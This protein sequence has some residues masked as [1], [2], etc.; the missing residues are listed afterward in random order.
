M[1]KHA[2]TRTRQ[3]RRQLRLRDGDV[4]SSL[5]MEKSSDT[6]CS[7]PRSSRSGSCDSVGD[8]LVG[9]AA[10][11]LEVVGSQLL[12]MPSPT[13]HVPLYWKVGNGMQYKQLLEAS[14]SDS[15]VVSLALVETE[16]REL[17]GTPV[18]RCRK[19]TVDTSIPSSAPRGLEN[20]DLHSLVDLHKQLEDERKALPGE[21]VVH[22]RVSGL[23]ATML[24][25]TG[26]SVSVISTRLWD[27]IHRSHPGWTLLPTQCRVKTVSGDLAKVRGSLVVEIQLGSKYYAHQ[28]VVID[29][30]EDLILGLD[31]IQKYDLNW[32]KSLG[33][34]LLWGEEVRAVRRYSTGDGRAR[35][36]GL[37]ETTVIP[38][39]TQV[40]VNTK[41][42]NGVKGQL[43]EWG[44]VSATGA[45]AG[46]HGV[47]A[48]RAL[49]DPTR[50][51]IPVPVINPGGMEVVLQ[52]N[53]DIALLLPVDTVG[54][55]SL[56]SNPKTMSD[57]EPD[58]GRKGGRKAL[59]TITPSGETAA[60]CR[61]GTETIQ[62]SNSKHQLAVPPRG[63]V[64]GGTMEKETPADSY[65]KSSAA[66]LGEKETI[67][68]LENE[69]K[70]DS[71]SKCRANLIPT[72]ADTRVDNATK[73]F[74]KGAASGLS[75]DGM[76]HYGRKHWS[77]VSDTE[78]D[79]DSHTLASPTEEEA[80]IPPHL[81]HLYQES[82]TELNTEEAHSLA[83]F[84]VRNADVFAESASD[85]GRT[86]LV[87]HVIDT[88]E[89]LPIKQPPRRVPVHRK[90]LVQ[91]EVG[92]MLSRGVI[93]PSDGPW[94]SPIV[95][96][97]K[98]D[99]TTRFCVDYRRL[100]E[101]T[102][103]DAYPLPR[104]EDNLDALQGAKYFSTLDLISGYWQVEVTPEDR[105][106]TAFTVGGGGLY[107][108]IT[109]PFG[110]CNAPGTF[111]RLME[112]VLQGLQWETAV[113]YID[114]VV[115]Y[116]RT[117]DQHLSRLEEVLRRLRKAGLKLKPSKCK[118]LSR[119]VEF[120][121][122]I[123]SEQGVEVDPAKVAKIR[124]WPM[125][126]NLRAVRSFV[127]LCA[128]YRRFVPEFSTICK[129][130]FLLTQKGQPFVWG[131]AQQVAMDHMKQLLMSAPILGYPQPTGMY[132][133][134]TD[135]SNVG[136]GAVLSQVQDGEEKVICYASKVL[137][138]AQRN[139]CVTRRELLA[140]VEFVK[141]F[142]HYLYGAKFLVRTDHAALYWLLRKKDPE[143]QMARWIAL[144][145]AYDMVVQHRP[146]VKHGNVWR[147]AEM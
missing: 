92:K 59:V 60:S 121:G 118:L 91:E 146:G 51:Y 75:D 53:L 101:V 98:K 28:F 17:D 87:Q 18:M 113:L 143:G 140:I 131:D 74:R 125:P 111:Q 128:Y 73:P 4:A 76:Y 27:E 133:L 89:A 1:A 71:N 115:V 97:T 83:E 132:V 61:A 130:L 119:R 104:I 137:N 72:K 56:R 139:Y 84:L 136:I 2:R 141:Q 35:R 63:T 109:M 46:S 68:T 45:L 69:T 40:V 147:V 126:Q 138:K 106:K 49:V 86:S 96:V 85:L 13:E 112:R 134:D 44:M 31:F 14:G 88:G 8:A 47:M 20:L 100:N 78:S 66:P 144:M 24:I 33:T 21:L 26:A 123:V 10:L 55:T 80:A 41:V 145:Q 64:D 37:M 11:E 23:A 93:E 52:R 67:D 103:K 81:R 70:L 36:L 38:A 48:G 22:R 30:A 42:Q 116:A 102:R 62:D 32:D 6:P 129:P 95:L 54:V 50:D 7:T 82:V 57:K 120:L 34:L 135:A 19:V 107:R 58:I 110:L 5:T 9:E 142:H 124:D 3:R 77:E 43:P 127:G 25:D 12:T 90:H 65:P 122:H 105:D 114:D 108:F 16:R 99:G 79:S 39:F 117:V 15:Q 29:V 94:S